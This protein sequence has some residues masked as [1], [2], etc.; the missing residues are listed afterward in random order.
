MHSTDA[1][2]G[3]SRARDT[4]RCSVVGALRWKLPGF[5]IA[6]SRN[7]AANTISFSRNAL[8][9][10]SRLTTS[11]CEWRVLLSA[12][13]RRVAPLDLQ[14][15]SDTQPNSSAH[16]LVHARWH[17]GHSFRCAWR[18]GTHLVHVSC[19]SAPGRWHRQAPQRCAYS[20][21]GH[22]V[23]LRAVIV[24]HI[25]L[26]SITRHQTSQGCKRGSRA[27][28]VPSSLCVL[29]HR[30]CHT[31]IHTDTTRRPGTHFSSG[32]AFSGSVVQVCFFSLSPVC[33]MC[34]VR[35]QRD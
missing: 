19:L 14:W 29:P 1:G 21:Y 30:V 4:E 10:S 20:L 24:E 22:G 15:P 12:A 13:A 2:G 5:H 11:S 8:I 25:A 17:A 3:S 9:C 31:T 7:I 6:A 32:I 23:H 33:V 18:C 16:L 34:N 27:R 28:C 35:V 26:R